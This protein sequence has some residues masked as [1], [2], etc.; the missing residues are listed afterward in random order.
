M[1]VQAQDISGFG[2]K[3]QQIQLLFEEINKTVHTISNLK[4]NQHKYK[5]QKVLIFSWNCDES[6][7]LSD[8]LIKFKME[9]VEYDELQCN[10]K[11]ILF[12]FKSL[13]IKN[14]TG[15]CFIASDNKY[16]DW[17]IR[18]QFHIVS[19]HL[20]CHVLSMLRTKCSTLVSFQMYKIWRKKMHLQYK[21]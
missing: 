7:L 8:V 12:S 3:F 15:T 9:L 11:R 10:N 17:I 4:K 13:W 1:N 5:L 20:I 14:K 6:C 2:L 19:T 18:L 21:R 16:R